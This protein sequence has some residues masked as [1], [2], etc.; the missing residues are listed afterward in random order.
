[1]N[2]YE[3]I[4]QMIEVSHSAIASE[5]RQAVLDVAKADDAT[6]TAAVTRLEIAY[7]VAI[8]AVKVAY[9]R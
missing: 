7:L 2:R 9:A 4:A 6:I 1:M 5:L 3:A 8:N